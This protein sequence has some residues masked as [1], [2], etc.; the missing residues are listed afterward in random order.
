MLAWEERALET[1]VP[2]VPALEGPTLATAALALAVS[3]AAAFTAAGAERASDI[4]PGFMHGNQ[5]RKHGAPSS[6]SSYR[7]FRIIATR[8]SSQIT[9]PKSEQGMLAAPRGILWNKHPLSLLEI[10]S[11]EHRCCRLLHR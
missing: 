4:G 1:P 6:R 2:E 7:A 8:W 11:I 5:G 9:G 3:G 10:L